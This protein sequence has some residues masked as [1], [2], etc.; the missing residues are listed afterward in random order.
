MTAALEGSEWSAARL[1]RTLPPGKDPVP[2]V[3]EAGWPPGPVW[4]G[5]KSRPPG[6]WCPD[7][8][9]RSWVAI[10][11]ELPGPC[12]RQ[13]QFKIILY[14]QNVMQHFLYTLP[15]IPHPRTFTEVCQRNCNLYCSMHKVKDALLWPYE[16]KCPGANIQITHA[17]FRLSIAKAMEDTQLTIVYSPNVLSSPKMNRYLP[18]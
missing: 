10:P 7:R 12:M 6:I 1:G 11:T 16:A 5:R 9:A 3:Q 8:S 17:S 18:Y 15:Y 4:T 13:Y 2:I 14:G